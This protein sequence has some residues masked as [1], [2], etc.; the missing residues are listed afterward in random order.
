MEQVIDALTG[1][2]PLPPRALLLTFDDGYADHYTY[3]FPILDEMG[4]QGSF[5]PSARSALRGGVLA[6]NKVHLVLASVDDPATIAR[7]VLDWVE[8]HGERYG[9]EPA[10]RYRA[11]YATSTRFDGPEVGFVKRMLQHG[12]PDA[13]RAALL[14]ALFDRFVG[15]AEA[16]LAEELYAST[17]QLRLMLRH[18]MHVGGHGVDHRW[19]TTVGDEELATELDGSRDLLVHL[20]VAPSSWTFAYP[21]GDANDAVAAALAARGCA[22]AFTIEPGAAHLTPDQRLRL[23]RY[24]TNDL[25]PTASD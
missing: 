11:R 16:T 8:H 17:D 12:L 18:G 14:D 15:I 24:D 4:L 25:P 9:L 7:S 2:E 5:F 21:Y 19:L 22:A 23:P 3:A 10:D 20:G 1:G 13:P 6:P